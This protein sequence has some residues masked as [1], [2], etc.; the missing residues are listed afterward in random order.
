M[1]LQVHK[2]YMVGLVFPR[3]IN[4]IRPLHLSGEWLSSNLDASA[5]NVRSIRRHLG[6]VLRYD[7]TLK[8]GCH[9]AWVVS[10]SPCPPVC[11]VVWYA[12][13]GLPASRGTNAYSF[14]EIY[15]VARVYEFQSCDAS[16][17]DPGRRGSYEDES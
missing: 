9:F 10:A 12:E 11:T 14:E 1:A 17:S 16:I 3:V 5:R 7:D 13:T 2:L 8:D 4:D 6:L 15:R